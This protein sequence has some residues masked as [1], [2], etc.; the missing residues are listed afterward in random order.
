MLEV[1]KLLQETPSTPWCFDEFEIPGLALGEDKTSDDALL[2]LYL[3]VSHG[4]NLVALTGIEPV[5]QP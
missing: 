1:G 2:V 3:F 4:Q 5:F